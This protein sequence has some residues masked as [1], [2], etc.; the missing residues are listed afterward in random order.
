MGKQSGD[1]HRQR[2]LAP[3]LSHSEGPPSPGTRRV[4]GRPVK[5]SRQIRPRRPRG[6]GCH[7]AP[8]ASP[9][10]GR[11]LRRLPPGPVDR[12]RRPG[13][14]AP[15]RGH[16]NA[17]AELCKAGAPT[18]LTRR[19]PSR[20]GPRLR[21]P[22]RG[23]RAEPGPASEGGAPGWFLAGF[24]VARRCVQQRLL[25]ATAC[26][27]PP[28]RARAVMS[29]SVEPMPVYTRDKENKR[30]YANSPE[31]RQPQSWKLKNA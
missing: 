21:V 1:A 7:H 24:C 31:P 26:D 4:G 14:S 10:A 27:A 13:P 29:E 28:G 30:P 20:R 17:A 2:P 6:G 9:L 11:D 8:L 19:G 18:G 25:H 3:T 12:G 23:T 22:E 16:G 5:A 15:W